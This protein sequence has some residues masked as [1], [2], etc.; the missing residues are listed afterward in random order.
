LRQCQGNEHAADVPVDSVIKYTEQNRRADSDGDTQERHE[1]GR[2]AD[3]RQGN[4]KGH[5]TYP[6]THGVAAAE[7]GADQQLPAQPTA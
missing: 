6:E 5:V 1:A 3:H 7:K 2:A 4:R